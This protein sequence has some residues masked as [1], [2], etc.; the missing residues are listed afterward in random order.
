MSALCD[1][2]CK[3][4]IKGSSYEKTKK[5]LV[6]VCSNFNFKNCYDKAYERDMDAIAPLEARFNVIHLAARLNQA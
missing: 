6:V 4:N 5:L 3:L 1:R 2:Q